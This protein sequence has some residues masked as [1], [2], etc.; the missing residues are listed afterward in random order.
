MNLYRI[1]KEETGSV[2]GKGACIAV[3]A[4]AVLS[5]TA[6]A[7]DISGEWTAQIVGQNR[8]VVR[9]VFEFKVEDTKL[10]GSILG[11][12]ETERPI[13]DGKVKGDKISFSMRE[14]FGDRYV[15][16][17]YQGKI[18]GDTIKFKATRTDAIKMYVEFTAIRAR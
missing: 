5:A 15:T 3:V 1:W 17:I 6:W 14:Y 2:R 13:L 4:W 18:S 12:Q 10:T 9:A 11:Y 8:T 7:E 16:Y